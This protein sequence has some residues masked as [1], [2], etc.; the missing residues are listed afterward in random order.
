MN[1]EQLGRLPG[2]LT[3]LGRVVFRRNFFGDCRLTS[4][5]E[6][7]GCS[8]WA[9][10]PTPAVACVPPIDRPPGRFKLQQCKALHC[11]GVSVPLPTCNCTLKVG[12]K[13]FCAASSDPCS[14]W[15]CFDSFFFARRPASGF[16]GLLATSAELPHTFCT[17]G[18]SMRSGL[19]DVPGEVPLRP[20]LMICFGAGLA[21]FRLP[22]GCNR[23]FNAPAAWSLAVWAPLL[24]V[25]VACPFSGAIAER[26]LRLVST[27]FNRSAVAFRGGS[28]FFSERYAPALK[29]ICPLGRTDRTPPRF[30]SLRN[31]KKNTSAPR[32]LPSSPFSRNFPPG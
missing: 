26:S 2:R 3:S 14:A 8:L 7:E 23:N 4:A 11:C 6:R 10:A 20:V 25:L 5:C 17:R 31:Q 16:C 15:F 1:P 27:C 18:V 32:V 22:D 19:L 13:S 29:V 28:G 12:V 30:R 24:A 21:S 9:P